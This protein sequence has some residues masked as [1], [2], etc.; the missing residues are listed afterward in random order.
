M[1]ANPS[2]KVLV[3]CGDRYHP[4]STV[5]AGLAP[6]VTSAGLHFHWIEDASDWDPQSL[7]GYSAV[8]LAKSNDQSSA[9]HLPWMTEAVQSVL[10]SFI[11]SG[12]GLVAVHS[13]MASYSEIRQIRALTGGAF[14]NHPPQC[15]VGFEPKPGHPLTVGVA[16]FSAVDE[17]YEMALDDPTAEVFLHSRSIHGIQPAGWTRQEGAGRVCVL[18]PGHNAGVWLQASMQTL[19]SNVLCWAAQTPKY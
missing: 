10:V 19:L 15:E 6:L 14:L 5:R 17:Q 11:R 13:G 4:A 12:N 18:A 7:T 16:Q 2:R 1:T 9:R 8:L 3:F